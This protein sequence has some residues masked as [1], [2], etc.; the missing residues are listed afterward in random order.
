MNVLG[1]MMATWGT[2]G[3]PGGVD[4]YDFERARA[5]VVRAAVAAVEPSLVTIETIGGAQPVREMG[6]RGVVEESFRIAEGPTTGVVLSADGYIITS[7]FNFAREPSIITATLSDGRQLVARLVARDHIRRLALVKV[8]ATG[9]TPPEWAPV[10]E[11]QVGQYAIA[12]GRGLGGGT[13]VSLGIVSAPGRRN[14]NAVQTDAKVSPVNYGGPLV[15]IEGRVIGILVPMAGSGGALAGAEWYDGGIGFAIYK[16]RLDQVYDRLAAGEDIEQG[17]IGVILEADDAESLIPLLD[18]ILPPTRGVRI[19]QVARFSPAERA[20]LREG[21]KI[22]AIDGQP[23]GDLMEI[24][25]RLSDRAAGE[26]ITLSIKRRWRAFDVTL[27]LARAA[28]IGRRPKDAAASQ[29]AADAAPATPEG[30]SK[31]EKQPE[32]KPEDDGAEPRP[33]AD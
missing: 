23:T 26:Q 24:Q 30:D 32:D 17:K 14:G 27:T 3:Q 21:D 16:H 33:V 6:P 2:V 10:G 5:R 15:D 12:C 19:Q 8:D 22:T 20:R 11:V 1:V 7:S 31:D 25:R 13:F 9:L 28:D 4:P 18:K 29:P